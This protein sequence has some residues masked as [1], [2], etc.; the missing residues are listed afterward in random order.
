M[1]NC[2][3]ISSCMAT[4]FLRFPNS[5]LA[6]AFGAG[7]NAI[8]RLFPR[9]GSPNLFVAGQTAPQGGVCLVKNRPGWCALTKAQSP[10][11]TH[12]YVI[13]GYRSAERSIAYG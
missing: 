3:V 13:D 7:P 12:I 1:P 6:A 5:V 2:L 8:G 11:P 10:R 9:R 4:V